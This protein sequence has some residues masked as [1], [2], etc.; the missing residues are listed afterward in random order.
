[1]RP[2]TAYVKAAQQ[3][4]A[5]QKIPAPPCGHT[6]GGLLFAAD[7][8]SIPIFHQLPFQPEPAKSFS[9][10]SLPLAWRSG[11]PIAMHEVTCG[12]KM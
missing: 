5:F 2:P 8:S 10:V 1:M 7:R 9:F 11:D 4:F 6:A 12:I 3:T